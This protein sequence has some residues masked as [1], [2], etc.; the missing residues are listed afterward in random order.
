M[1]EEQLDLNEITDMFRI[2]GV[3]INATLE[4]I[5]HARNKLISIF[6]PDR[7]PTNWQ[8]TTKELENHV[9]LVQSAYEYIVQNYDAIQATLGYLPKES[10]TSRLPSK[11]RSHWVYIQVESQ[12]KDM[13]H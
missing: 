13:L 10:L 9:C 2:L 8:A 5:R 1:S 6:H 12:S 11:T 4:E 3:N 7:K